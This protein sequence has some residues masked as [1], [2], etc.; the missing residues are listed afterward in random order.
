MGRKGLISLTPVLLGRE[1]ELRLTLNTFGNDIRGVRSAGEPR[2]DFGRSRSTHFARLALLN[3]Y[4]SKDSQKRL[5]FATD[6]NG[7]LEAH[8]GEIFALTQ[9]PERIWGCCAGYKGKQS[10]REFI[11][12]NAIETEAEYVAFGG[13]NLARIQKSVA[14]RERFQR[15]LMEGNSKHS[16]RPLPY[17]VRLDGAIRTALH[18]V[19]TPFRQ[20][21]SLLYLALFVPVLMWRQGAREVYQAA[22]QANASLD[23][24]WWIAILNNLLENRP[25]AFGQG[26][27]QAQRRVSLNP[28]QG[29]VP[30]ENAVLHNQLTLLT[31]IK[32][33][34]L[35][36]LRALMGLI[37][38]YAEVSPPHSFLDMSIIHSVRWAIIDEGKRLLMLSNYDGTWENYIDEFVAMISSSLDALWHTS[39]IYPSAGSND[40]EALKQ[41]LRA[42]QIPAN[43]FYS[44][45]PEATVLNLKQDLRFARRY[46]WSLR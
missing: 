25:K 44:A 9:R 17:I 46:E 7:S 28:V 3:N 19:S 24:V 8:L 23:R 4:N 2:I 37:S 30:P 36:H 40:I 13:V 20:A 18:F 41:F 31:E 27:S 6:Y 11:R 21:F 16:F 39:P 5:L 1:E 33:E 22:M 10:F 45:Y 15:T 29:G 14:L 35:D 12:Q 32:P 43:V 42:N 26:F 34:K 38:L